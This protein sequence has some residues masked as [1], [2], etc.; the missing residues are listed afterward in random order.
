MEYVTTSVEVARVA[1]RKHSHVLR[2]IDR[3]RILLSDFDKYLCKVGGD[4]REFLLS[5]QALAM[6][7]V[8][9]GRSAI[10]MKW[11]GVCGKQVLTNFQNPNIT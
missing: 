9:Q 1:C 7:D 2:E 10:R 11:D 5:V 3:L 6:L 8:G 4:R